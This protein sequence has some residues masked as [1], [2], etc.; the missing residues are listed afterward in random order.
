MSMKVQVREVGPRDGLQ[1]LAK[2]MATKDKF[3]WIEGAHRAGLRHIEV[4]SF[5]PPALVPQLADTCEVVAFARTL[6][7]LK[8]AALAPN[9][10][11]AQAAVDAGVQHLVVPVS[12]TEAHSLANLRRDRTTVLRGVE[13]ITRLCGSTGPRVEASLSMAFGCSLEGP[14]AVAEVAALARRLA[15]AG[16]DEIRLADT[17]GVG[18]PARL[19][20]MVPA[21][22]EAV[23]PELIVGLHLHNT[24][25]QGLAMIVTAL[26][27]G[28]RSFDASLGGLGGCPFAPG[29]SGNVVTEDLVWL[30]S[31]MGYDTGV[32]LAELLVVRTDVGTALTEHMNGFVGA[33]PFLSMRAQ[34]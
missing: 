31:E 3:Q 16:V 15:D 9:A 23:P 22:R 5:V 6:L 20:E 26:D 8:V 29:A 34:N 30:L 7:D 28:L 1:S 32:D 14:V 4:G 25:G 18:N 27:L 12:A 10:K 17:A 11:G 13:A 24:R 2:V 33:A 19:R 21:V